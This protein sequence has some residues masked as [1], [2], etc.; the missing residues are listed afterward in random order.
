MPSDGDGM[1]VGP[2]LARL[3]DP[4]SVVINSDPEL[5]ERVRLEAKKLGLSRPEYGAP[6]PV[7]E[8][9]GLH[10]QMVQ[11]APLEI[12]HEVGRATVFQQRAE[13]RDYQRLW[14]QLRYCDAFGH[15]NVV[16]GLGNRLLCLT[17]DAFGLRFHH[18]TTQSEY[19]GIGFAIVMARHVLR[20]Q[21]PDWTWVAVD[22]EM[23]LDAG[24]ALPGHSLRLHSR[25]GTTMRPDYFLLGYRSEG[26]RSHAR[27]VVLESKGTHYDSRAV[28]Q[29]GKAAYQLDSVR[30]GGR[31]PPGLM[32]AT[33]LGRSRIAV[34]ILDPD[35]DLDLWE[36]ATEQ[37]DE[38][39]EQ[40]DLAMTPPAL[41]VAGEAATS[42]APRQLSLFGDE[43][44]TTASPT[45]LAPAAAS[46]VEHYAIPAERSGWFTRVLGHTAAA[47]A[48]LFA[49]N[50]T[51]ARRLMTERQRGRTI[52]I[53]IDIDVGDLDRRDTGL[54]ACLG[55]S[56][57]V[58][59]SGNQTMEIFHGLDVDSFAAIEEASVGGF[60]AR[61]RSGPAEIVGDGDEVVIRSGDGAVTGF[62]LRQR[63][64]T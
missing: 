40:L 25:R 43:A 57:H 27:L 30:V 42:G 36:G 8:I 58:Q 51:L 41:E 20:R 2:A 11:V 53:D 55:T 15:G 18:K 38:S 23:V 17:E 62:R 5:A 22:A 24:F 46:V 14:A 49:G 29:M 32:V 13:M 56:H 12:L 39:V 33:V 48:A 16:F 4:G 50:G 61:M 52:D 9:P 47:A 59:W 34:N 35:G 6:K 54:G 26:T 28:K 60:V 1:D 10:G 44:A 64:Q 21:H 37:L 19:L 63:D 31:T 7:E 45:A 3:V